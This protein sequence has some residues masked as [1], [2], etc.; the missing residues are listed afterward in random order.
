MLDEPDEPLVTHRIEKGSDVDVYN[1]VH[2]RLGNTDGES[3]QRIMLAAPGSKPVREPQKILLVNRIEH[4]HHRTLDD[5]VFQRRDPQRSFSSIPFRNELA[6][7]GLR[8]IGAA[9]NACM[10]L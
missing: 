1:E 10:Q 7:R 5:S 4:F 9:M 6:P 3:I 8:P 2:R